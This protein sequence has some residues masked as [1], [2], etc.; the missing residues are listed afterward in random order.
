MSA[1]CARRIRAAAALLAACL[2][3][4][5]PASFAEGI[6]WRFAGAQEGAALMADNDAYYAGMSQNDI[7]YRMQRKGATLE[8]LRAFAAEQARDF[9]GDEQRA[10]SGLV[11]EILQTCADRGYIL[12]QVGEIVFVKTTAAE[13]CG[14]GGYTHGTQIY[15]NALVGEYLLRG[16]A[17]LTDFCR[18]L[19]AHEL[20]HCLTRADPAFRSALYAILGFEV[21]DGEYEIAPE[22]RA[23]MIQNP[24]V[25][26]HDAAAIFHIHGEPRKCLTVFITERPFEQAGDSFFDTMATGLVPVD[27]PGTLYAARDA[28]DF[29]DV[30]GRNTDYIVDPEETLA[31]N[32]SFVLCR[33]LDADYPNPEIIRA[34]DAALRAGR[35]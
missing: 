15:L 12:P 29:W 20:F 26:R 30:F 13:E 32:F 18:E 16:D 4:C 31:D 19:L 27:D 7:D 25:E 24:D 1:V 3:S 6:A 34:I 9:T 10:I 28:D 14:C 33:G 2:L 11:E 8:E 5:L 23:R 17:A 21:G 22:I 35:Y